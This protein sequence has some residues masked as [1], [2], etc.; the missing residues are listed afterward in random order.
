MYFEEFDF[1]I[2]GII[3]LD[4]S[5][6]LAMSIFIESTEVIHLGFMTLL[7]LA[8]LKGNADEM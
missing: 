5:S 1:S 6:S 7:L 4:V 8:H 3:P 2:I